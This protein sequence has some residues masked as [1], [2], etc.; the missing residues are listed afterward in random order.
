MNST[1][2]F[3]KYSPYNSFIHK[4]DPRVKLFLSLCFVV[5]IFLPFNL[6]ITKLIFSGIYLLISFIVLLI[7]KIKIRDF[8]S[9]L[10]GMWIMMVFLLVAYIFIP[11]TMDSIVQS[12]VA[13]SI[14]NYTVYWG[15]ICQAGY[16]ILRLIIMLVVM[17]IL[18]S[19]TSPMELTYGF[20]FYMTPLK[21]FHFPV[22][23]VSM[24]LSIA[25]R[26]IPTLLEE[27]NR[28]MKAQASRGVDFNH[29]GLIKKF[30]AVISLI[31]PLFVSSI[32]RSEELANAMEARGYDPRAKRTKYRVLKFSWRDLLAFL[33]VIA[34]VGGVIT[35][36][37]IDKNIPG[38]ID[39]FSFFGGKSF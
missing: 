35:A 25:L 38:G 12:P 21:I 6:W 18:T 5:V 1:L 2:S 39:F 31:I 33:L 24:T 16:I 14:G 17:M 11:N 8:L 7:A 32:E 10:K 22:H 37:V 20:E 29:G 28:I 26:F 30:K 15:V 13:F 3:G 27:T 36:F 19:S 9:D 4:L 34:F 23:E